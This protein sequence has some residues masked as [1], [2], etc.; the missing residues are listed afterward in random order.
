[1]MRTSI[2]IALFATQLNGAAAFSPA[3]TNIVH[4]QHQSVRFTSPTTLYMAD[5]ERD[6]SSKTGVTV[7]TRDKEDT[8]TEMEED[9]IKEEMWRVMLHND[10]V[11]TFNYVIS[12]LIKVIGTIDKKKAHD[13]CV[14]T[15]GQGQAVVAEGC[16]KQQAMK[17]CVGMQRAGLTASIAPDGKFEG[18]DPSPEAG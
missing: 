5:M 15:H 13:I 10:E 17:Y 11:H 18:G 4:A 7:I 16:Y 6:M 9:V 12:S 8:D 14:Q 1:M 3:A 2:V